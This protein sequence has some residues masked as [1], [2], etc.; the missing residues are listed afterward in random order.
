MCFWQ[1]DSTF[2]HCFSI[3]RVIQN[4]SLKSEE[5][6]L[7]GVMLPDKVLCCSFLIWW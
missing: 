1:N 3:Y 5:K 6:I 2:H 7:V 4:T